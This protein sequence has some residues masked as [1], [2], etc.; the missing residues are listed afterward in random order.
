MIVVVDDDSE[1]FAII[2]EAIKT[3]KPSAKLMYFNDAEECLNE[4]P[5]MSPKPS[6]ILLDINM[7]KMNGFEFLKEFKK[8]SL[9]VPVVIMSTTSIQDQK[10]SCAALGATGY[11]KKPNTWNEMTEIAKSVLNLAQTYS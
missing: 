1:D 7:P 6:V 4:L 2:S 5:V 8:T 3:L 11:L 9:S 10:R